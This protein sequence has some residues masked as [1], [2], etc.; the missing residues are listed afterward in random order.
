[1]K[2]FASL[3]L[4]LLL[5][6]IISFHFTEILAQR[7]KPYDRSQ[8]FE[9]GAV[10]TD[11]LRRVPQSKGYGDHEE[12]IVIV[13]FRVVSWGMVPSSKKRNNQWKNF[14]GGY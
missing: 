3:T 14:S 7:N 5:V 1:M 2:N 10:T 13:R 12:K 4:R 6:F 11:D 9:P 8:W